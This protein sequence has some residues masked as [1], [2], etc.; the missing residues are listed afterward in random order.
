MSTR[1]AAKG[2]DHYRERHCSKK[3]RRFSDPSFVQL[4]I[5]P[6]ET[7][8]NGEREISKAQFNPQRICLAEFECLIL[9]VHEPTLRHVNEFHM[10]VFSYEDRVHILIA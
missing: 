2:I 9:R 10:S 6:A 1:V 3:F 8:R 7:P 4:V 5:S